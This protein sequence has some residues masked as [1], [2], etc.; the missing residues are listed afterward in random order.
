MRERDEDDLF[1]E[2]PP[3]GAGR[4]LD[5]SGPVVERRDRD[6]LGQPW[7]NLCDACLHGIDDLLSIHAGACHHD[8]ADGF[9]G[10]LDQGRQRERRR[11][12]HV[13]DLLHVDRRPR[14]GTDHDLLDVLDRGDEPNTADDQPRAIRLQDVATHIEI[15]LAHGRHDRTERD[16]VLTKAV[17]IHVDLVLLNIPPTDATSATP[18]TALSW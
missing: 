7:L 14:R 10:S 18:G 15:A 2:R 11:H 3:Q 5:E 12:L 9:L 4:L 6:T 13:R 8:A 1:D 17:R 16:R